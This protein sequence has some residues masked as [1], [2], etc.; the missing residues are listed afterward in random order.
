MEEGWPQI[1]IKWSEE[2]VTKKASNSN[3]ANEAFGRKLFKLFLHSPK[4]IKTKILLN[5]P[6]TTI[7]PIMNL[8]PIM[9]VPL[10]NV[11]HI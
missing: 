5:P 7:A 10:T 2:D 8:L 9:V 6:P 3:I 1:P 11:L 4:Y